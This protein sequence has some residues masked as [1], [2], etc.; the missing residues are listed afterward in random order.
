M[1][2]HYT[3]ADLL[4]LATKLRAVIGSTRTLVATGALVVGDAKSTTADIIS[5]TKSLDGVRADL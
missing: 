5:A 3:A 1:G 2:S 4:K